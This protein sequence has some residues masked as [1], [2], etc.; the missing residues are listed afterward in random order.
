ME[1]NIENKRD[2]IDKLNFFWKEN[3]IKLL[4]FFSVFFLILFFFIFWNINT[5]KKNSL[6][7]EKY[8]EAGLKLVEE[9]K[10]KS[11]EI[12]EEIILSKNKF[13]SILALGSILDNDLEKNE[14]KILDYFRIVE[15]INLSED[16]RDLLIFK[17]ALYLIKISETEKGN[18]LLK[19]L[20]D[21][22]SKYKSLA[23]NFLN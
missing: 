17:K 23:Q 22:N 2:I 15:E 11:K 19:K 3:K 12:F 1:Q 16:Q 18:E 9:N 6:I 8:I 4:I 7:S 10:T 13:Y 21:N 14:V 20:I 5:D